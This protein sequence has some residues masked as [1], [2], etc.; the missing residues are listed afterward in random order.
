MGLLYFF[1]C[2]DV[3]NNRVIAV[4]SPHALGRLAKWEEFAGT[5]EGL[6]CLEVLN[7]QFAVTGCQW[8]LR[9]EEDDIPE[10]APE[11]GKDPELHRALQQ[12]GVTINLHNFDVEIVTWRSGKW[13]PFEEEPRPTVSVRDLRN[14]MM[15]RHD[16]ETSERER[17]NK[18]RRR[19]QN[20]PSAGAMVNVTF[21]EATT[22]RISFTAH[23]ARQTVKSVP[24]VGEN[25]IV[26]VTQVQ[27]IGAN[28]PQ[29]DVTFEGCDPERFWLSD[30]DT[31]KTTNSQ[32][33]VTIHFVMK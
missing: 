25:K 15:A 32:C 28:G 31:W 29:Y 6:K 16:D 18:R 33:D 17:P 23:G 10:K 19:Q 21:S 3:R 12:E 1:V 7:Q 11:M 24:A 9:D 26:D 20:H 4:V 14:L 27:G 8:T 30:N 2:V 5:E 13:E 22:T